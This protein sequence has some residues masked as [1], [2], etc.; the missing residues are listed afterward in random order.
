M[1]RELRTK[2]QQERQAVR[3]GKK[4]D[5]GAQVSHGKASIAGIN[6]QERTIPY[7]ISTPT[8]DRH[9]DIL[10]PMG[11]QF[12]NYLN[13]PVVLF[14]HRSRE[15]PIG[16]GLNPTKDE[17]CVQLIKKFMTKEENPLADNIYRLVKGGWMNACSVGFV[18]VEW[19]WAD[20]RDETRGFWDID[21]LKWELTESSPCPVPANPDA[22]AGA[23]SAGEDLEP[24]VKWLED[25]LDGLPQEEQMKLSR[26][27]L[28]RSWVKAADHPFYMLV[29][30]AVVDELDAREVPPATS[31][32]SQE[33]EPQTKTEPSAEPV[34][35]V[36]VFGIKDA[37]AT[38][39][40]QFKE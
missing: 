10:Y 7:V 32:A 34:E 17:T 3:D 13:N 8:L 5:L 19:E 11:C 2:L 36:F 37:P 6:D 14:A 25:T 21:Y 24:L 40:Y 28:E 1:T 27:V 20:I 4:E 33:P 35:P 23:K 38:V 16:K 29:R 12:E 15:L 26:Q 39:Q 9:G 18:P 22:L 31:E 30:Q